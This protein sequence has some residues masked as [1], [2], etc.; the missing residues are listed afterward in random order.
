MSETKLI[1]LFILPMGLFPLTEEPL[2]VFEPR[3][4]QMLDDCLLNELPF[5]YIAANQLLDDIDGWT[6][7][8]E[9]GVLTMAE[10]VSE[11]GTNILFTA[12]GKTRFKILKIIPAALP[13]EEF[14]DVFP[15]VDE[16]VELYSEENPEGKLYVRA[17]IEELPE[18]NGII[19]SNRWE[20][21]VISWT[22]HVVNMNSI[23]EGYYLNIDDILPIMKNEFMPYN[24]TKLWS[25]CQSIL[26]SQKLRQSAL[27]ANTTKEV[28]ELLEKSLKEKK[29]QIERI[30]FMI[31]QEEE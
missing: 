17:E 1:P 14:N 2:R 19:E 3:Y 22:E 13:A 29:S 16:L 26:D 27:S 28:V 4:K 20:K 5:G 21:L 6:P 23:V 12:S 25:A 15:S 10:N 7:P 24:E 18:L 9:F 8:S 31:E 11:Q 30:N